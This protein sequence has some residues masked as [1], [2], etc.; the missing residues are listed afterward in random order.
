MVPSGKE[1]VTIDGPCG[2]PDPPPQPAVI[3][4]PKTSI[5]HGNTPEKLP[6]LFIFIVA[7]SR[8][9]SLP[10]DMIH[11]LS[12]TLLRRNLRRSV[13]T[14]AILPTYSCAKRSKNRSWPAAIFCRRKQRQAEPWGEERC[15]CGAT[16]RSMPSLLRQNSQT[17]RHYCGSVEK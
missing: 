1:V 17:V 2:G 4:R 5:D 14:I 12:V 3:E 15:H 9:H 13:A 11:T 8:S 7:S 16:S 10:T 6:I